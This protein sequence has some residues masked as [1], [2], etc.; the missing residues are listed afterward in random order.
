DD[1]HKR[2]P[3]HDEGTAGRLMPMYIQRWD[4]SYL[5]QRGGGTAALATKGVLLAGCGAVG[6]H[7]AFELVRAGVGALT[8][9]DHDTL[10]PENSYRHVLGRRYWGRQKAEALKEEIE[11]QLPYVRV[12]AV[13]NTLE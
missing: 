9:V 8:L 3:L 4:H 1:V 7:L 2:Q 11:A 10:L 13:V 6:G 12:T 5:V